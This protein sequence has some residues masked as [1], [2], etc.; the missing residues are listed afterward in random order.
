VKYDKIKQIE[1]ECF[2][3][4]VIDGKVKAKRK[5]KIRYTATLQIRNYN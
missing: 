2:V 5:K 4:A 3:I 1:K